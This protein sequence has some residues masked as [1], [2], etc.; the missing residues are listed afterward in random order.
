MTVGLHPNYLGML[1]N[2]NG[3]SPAVQ[4][5]LAEYEDELHD[6]TLDMSHIQQYLGRKALLTVAG[7]M[8]HSQ[9]ERIILDSAKELLDRSP[10]TQKSQRLQVDSFSL[11]GQD[12]A[13]LVSALA[14]SAAV[15]Q[16]HAAAKD[17][18]VE[19]VVD[20]PTPP[21][22]P[23]QPTKAEVVDAPTSPTA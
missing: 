3:G 1:L 8:D 13:A 2:P 23:L 10:E 12:V 21:T 18:L 6:K 19:I 11:D 17:G 15:A 9:N 4:A 14:E 20:N 22:V 16:L 7:L 5:L